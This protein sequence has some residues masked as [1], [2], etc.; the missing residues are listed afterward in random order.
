MKENSIGVRNN[1]KADPQ[2]E[3]VL[4]VVLVLGCFMASS[5]GFNGLQETKLRA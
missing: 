1:E 4:Q 5:L 2:A 3:Q